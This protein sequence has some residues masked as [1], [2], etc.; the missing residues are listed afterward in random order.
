VR[1]EAV[2]ADPRLVHESALHHPPAEQ[3][4]RTAE[5]EHQHQSWRQPCL[6]ATPP[7]EPQHRQGKGHAHH[8]PEQA[9]CV[10]EPEDPLEAVQIHAGV[11]VD[12][13]G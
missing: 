2:L 5:H 1:R 7:E 4:L 3:P 12:V 11:L 9:V 10:L 6:H 13:L 8:A